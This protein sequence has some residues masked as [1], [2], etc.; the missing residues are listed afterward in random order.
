MLDPRVYRA[1]FVPALL[2]LV[3]VAFSLVD[4]PRP[5]QT[6]LA[7]DAFDHDRAFRT[8]Q[9]LARDFPDR[10]PGGLGDERLADLVARRM[11]GA[12]F[13]VG[14]DRFRGRTIDGRR[15]LRTVVGTRTGQPGPAIVVVAHR[16]AAGRVAEAELS[17][18]AGLIELTRVFAGRRTRRTLTLVS[19]S[20]GSGGGAGAADVVRRLRAG[21][22]R[23]DAVLVLGDLASEQL[24]KPWVLPWSDGPR[25]APVRLRRTLEAAVRS[26]TGQDAGAPR[27]AE[28]LARLAF[29]FATGEEGRFNEAGFPAVRLSASGARGPAAGDPVSVDRL[30]VFGRAALRTIDALDNARA[31][32]EPVSAEIVTRGKVLPPWTMRLMVGAL[33]L[34]VLLAAIDGLA[35]VRRRHEPVLMWLR[36]LAAL[37]LPFAV[38]ALAARLLGVAGAVDAPGAAVPAGRVPADGVALAVLAVLF[39]ICA[40]AVPRLA[41]WFGVRG[42]VDG[43]APAAAVGVATVVLAALVWVR[44]PFAAALLVLPA[45]LWLMVP[46]LPLRR[47]WAVL[48]TLVALTPVAWVLWTYG[49]ALGLGPGELP[50]SLTLLVAGGQVSPLALAALC[51]IAGCAVAAL[52]LALRPAPDEPAR[53]ARSVLGPQ[54][55]AGPGSL[56]GTD[57]AMRLRR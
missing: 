46:A 6:T 22:T 17:A 41:H 43:P 34:P 23:V 25:L 56:G 11:A 13:R 44:N 16:D 8:L 15:D 49:S 36:W 53:P 4:R 26:E 51:G 18:T 50:W 30:R 27:A 38:V 31:L 21:G 48:L 55:Y 1:G 32:D 29:P 2:A 14:V 45:H 33:L 35:R 5:F 9:G 37:I 7:P 12:G 52:R 39:A 20:G 24:R 19:T 3:V 54:G 47:L 57:S 42:T 28:Q 40:L 10:R